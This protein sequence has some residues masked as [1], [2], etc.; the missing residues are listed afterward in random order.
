MAIASRV[1]VVRDRRGSISVQQLAWKRAARPALARLLQGFAQAP[2]QL[3]ASSAGDYESKVEIQLPRWYCYFHIIQYICDSAASAWCA[4]S[5]WSGTRE[6]GYC[7]ISAVKNDNSQS[8]GSLNTSFS[9]L[10]VSSKFKS[11]RSLRT[12]FNKSLLLLLPI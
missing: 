6:S 2:Q 10:F 4:T 5:T 3:Q 7:R 12:S 11:S 1:A 9:L 8:A